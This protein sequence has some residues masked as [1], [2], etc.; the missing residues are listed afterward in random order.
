MLVVVALGADLAKPNFKF[1]GGERRLHKEIS[2]PSPVTIQPAASANSRSCEA[3]QF[4]G[5]VLLICTRY[6][7]PQRRF[8]KA[9]IEPS[10]PESGM[11]PMS[12]P[13]FLPTPASIISSSVHK[14]P[15]K[16][17]TSGAPIMRS[18]SSS[19]EAQV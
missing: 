18:N 2:R 17:S 16:K 4:K 6:L 19:S 10:G 12:R 7:R 9:A 15:S 8:I 3:V 1:V 14:V 11:W 13:V 5:L